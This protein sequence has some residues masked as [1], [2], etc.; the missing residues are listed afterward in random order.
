MISLVLIDNDYLIMNT[1]IIAGKN[2][3]LKL[4]ETSTKRV[5]EASGGG[6]AHIA[7]KILGA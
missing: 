6:I 4:L 2:S 5:D 1:H 3:Y 7:L